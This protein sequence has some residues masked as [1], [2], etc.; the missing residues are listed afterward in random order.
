[1]SFN[2]A[3][4]KI[5]E[6][7]FQFLMK[8]GIRSSVLNDF[9]FK[10]LIYNSFG[11]IKDTLPELIDKGDFERL[12]FEFFKDRKINL[13]IC[14][15]DRINYNEI[16][17][18]LFWAKDELVMISKLEQEYLSAEPDIDLIA[19]GINEMNQFGD[20]NTIDSLANG[21]ILKW[22]EIKKLPY[23]K[24]FD[25]QYKSVVEARIQKKLVKIKSKP[26]K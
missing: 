23:N 2:A 12:I 25:K 17:Y 21:D 26:K 22:E 6:D 14:D 4:S 7:E 3:L 19:A 16:L 18:F 9:D 10:S 20:L 1:M 24:V 15:I 11:F 5:S 13:F 8:N